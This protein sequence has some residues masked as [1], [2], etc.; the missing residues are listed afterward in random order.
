MRLRSVIPVGESAKC[1]DL[2]VAFYAGAPPE[3]SSLDKMEA[4]LKKAGLTMSAQE[5]A[6]HRSSQA[7]LI[8]SNLFRNRISVGTVKKGD[9][10]KHGGLAQAGE[11][12]L[13]ADGRVDGAG[14][15]DQRLVTECD[16]IAGR[17]QPAVSGCKGR[18]LPELGCRLYRKFSLVEFSAVLD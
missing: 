1:D 7:E 13:A 17:H 6:D 4:T 8:S 3:P 18:H 11:R 12:S 16:G 14:G 9:Y 5:F 10:V 15:R 2:M